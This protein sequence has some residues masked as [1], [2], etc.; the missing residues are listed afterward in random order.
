[1][2]QNFSR[3]Y[4]YKSNP[5]GVDDDSKDEEE[6][7]NLVTNKECNSFI[8]K[9]E[10]KPVTVEYAA[11]LSASIYGSGFPVQKMNNWIDADFEY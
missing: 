9:D 8:T 1:M 6:Y 7:W 3:Q 5:Q 4:R 11:D 2:A 10:R